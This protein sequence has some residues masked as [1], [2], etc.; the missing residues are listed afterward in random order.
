MTREFIDI[1]EEVLSY[2]PHDQEKWNEGD[3]SLVPEAFRDD[4]RFLKQPRSHFLAMN[5]LSHYG[6]GTWRG[7]YIGWYEIFGKTEKRTAW[8]E[9]GQKELEGILG[10]ELEAFRTKIGPLAEKFCKTPD[11]VVW[12][13]NPK[14]VTFCEVKLKNETVTQPE[15]M[16]LVLVK[17]YL[18]AD[19]RILR[20]CE[21]G[22]FRD[23]RRWRVRRPFAPVTTGFE[24]HDVQKAE[25]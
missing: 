12:R 23:P 8:M 21:V 2:D 19:A 15:F 5:A 25:E 14:R 20:F 6:A 10:P 3:K 16:G 4:P 9:R 17:S 22:D 7:L 11:L 1:N 13:M 24:R 18:G